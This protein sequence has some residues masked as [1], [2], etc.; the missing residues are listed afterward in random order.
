[1]PRGRTLKRSRFTEEQIIGIA[2]EHQ[3]GLWQR[4]FV[5]SPVSAMRPA[6][7]GVGGLA[8]WVSDAKGLRMLE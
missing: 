5:A 2:K 4:I 8:P 7:N 3:D 6:I 1:M